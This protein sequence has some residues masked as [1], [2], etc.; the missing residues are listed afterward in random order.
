MWRGRICI[1]LTGLV[2]CR[3]ATA[4]CLAVSAEWS[5]NLSN[6]D[7]RPAHCVIH[8]ILGRTNVVYDAKGIP[9]RIRGEAIAY[10]IRDCDNVTLRNIELDWERPCLTEA[11]ILEFG[12]GTTHVKIDRGLYPFVISEGRLLMTG[13][14][15][16][17]AV[18]KAK[19]YD[20]R[21]REHLP[22][23]G[24]VPF[25]GA[26]RELPDGTVELKKDFSPFGAG[27]NAGDVIVLR[28][29]L[30]DFP[31]IVVVNSRNVVL[32]DVVV[33]DAKGMGL[34]VQSSENVTWRGTKTAADRTSGVFPRRGAFASTHADASHFSNVKGRVTVENC[35]F[36]GMMDDAINVHS[37]C[38]A[39]TNVIGRRT[40]A[41]RYAH[42]QSVGLDLFKTGDRVRLLHGATMETSAESSVSSVRCHDRRSVEITL[43]EDVP[44]GWGVGDAVENADL[45]PSVVFRGN[46]VSRNRARGGCFT[47]P[48]PVLIESNLFDRV[49]GA[50]LLFAGDG[51]FWYE[52]G[53]CRDV[54]ICGNVFS[55]CCTCA[56]KHGHSKSVIAIA[57][58]VADGA[59]AQRGYHRNFRIEHNRFETFDVPLLYAASVENVRFAGNEVN[60]NRCYRGLGL[61]QFV[62]RNCQNMELDGR[63]VKRKTNRR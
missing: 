42:A 23:V 62:V 20:G 28:P 48:Q 32:E 58:N 55:N 45:Q 7:Q 16:T 12:D 19:L 4:G 30:R 36:D 22:E 5:L 10:C 24:D 34:L 18:Y 8:P 51:R 43:S 46:V 59:R 21:T 40:L 27:M 63:H 49:T 2:V 41:C 37:T 14:G 56:G 50:A 17:N 53:A 3:F 44:S 57:P 31:A 9:E 11:K 38:L 60:Y 33:H 13:P 52:S 29:R 54:T 1:A 39:V 61:P 35:W 15:W 26:A 6:H 47:T 25:D